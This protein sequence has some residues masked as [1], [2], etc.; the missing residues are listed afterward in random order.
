MRVTGEDPLTDP[1]YR[2]GV[3]T[4]RISDSLQLPVSTGGSRSSCGQTGEVNPVSGPG[5]GPGSDQVSVQVTS[6]MH[7]GATDGRSGTEHRRVGQRS[8]MLLLL[9]QLRAD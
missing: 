1:G 5:V 7:R 6:S 2:T 3:Y 8:V 9:L 4:Q